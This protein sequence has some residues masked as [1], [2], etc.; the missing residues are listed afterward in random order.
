MEQS[1]LNIQGMNC[2]HCLSQVTRVLS[3]LEGVRVDRVK[4]G[5]ATIGYEPRQITIKEITDA[6][7]E[8]G[9]ETLL[10]SGRTI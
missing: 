8:A 10:T 3:S 4:I 2:G 5:E 7:K 6:I 9:Y 1:T